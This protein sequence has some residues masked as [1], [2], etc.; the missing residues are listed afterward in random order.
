MRNL[1]NKDLFKVMRIV[2]KAEIK[3]RITELKP[4]ENIT[5][6]QYGAM[7]VFE[8]IEGAPEAEKDIFGFLAD[9][10]GVKP[11]ELEDDE[12]ELLPKIIEHLQG[13]EKLIN[14]LKQAFKSTN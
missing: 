9:I 7:L 14:F 10:G 11:K 3:K 12:F 1:N 4:P 13:Q 8:V 2:R 5:D 6:Q